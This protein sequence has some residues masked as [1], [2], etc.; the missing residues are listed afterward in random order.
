MKFILK[1]LLFL[2][3]LTLI[4]YGVAQLLMF[5]SPI[6]LVDKIADGFEDWTTIPIPFSNL[7]KLLSKATDVRDEIAK[8]STQMFGDVLLDVLKT[9]IAGFATALI[10]PP[11]CLLLKLF[12]RSDTNLLFRAGRLFLK[13]YLALLLGVVLVWLHQVLAHYITNIGSAMVQFAGVAGL[14]AL[15]YFLRIRKSN[16]PNVVRRVLGQY[17][18][19][20]I[21]QMLTWVCVALIQ[22]YVRQDQ[23]DRIIVVVIVWITLSFV[24]DLVGIGEGTFYKYKVE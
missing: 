8:F 18:F 19:P 16:Y 17:L 1:L 20:F 10:L 13:G 15:W 24:F 21:S 11:L 14:A 2:F 5:I 3:A 6:E 7:I 22:L 4:V 12:A 23:Y 9:V